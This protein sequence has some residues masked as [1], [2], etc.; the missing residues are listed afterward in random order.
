MNFK[1]TT[2]PHFYLQKH[3]PVWVL[4][5]VLLGQTTGFC[6]DPPLPQVATAV[7]ISETVAETYYVS[8][9]GDDANQALPNCPLKLL[10]KA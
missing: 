3:I 5:L 9:A 8:P 10:P 2:P 4:L 1:T 6:A 7:T